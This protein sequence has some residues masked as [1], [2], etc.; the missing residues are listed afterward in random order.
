MENEKII[1]PQALIQKFQYALNNHWGYIWGTAG[2]LWTQARQT[3]IEQTTDSDRENARKYG[4]KWIG[5]YVADCSG[6]FTW[7]FKQLGGTMYHGSNTM[8]DKW[9]TAKGKLKN[10]RRN[11]GKTL[12]PGT[13]VFTYN[14]TKHNRGHVGLYIGDGWVIEA[15]GTKAGVVKSKVTLDKWVEWGELKGVDYETSYEGN[16]V[17]V[18]PSGTASTGSSA[19]S[20]KKDDKTSIGGR[21]T[22]RKGDKG[23]YV[24]LL[25]TKLQQKGYDLGSYGIDGD[26]GSATEKAVKQFQEDHDI[27]VDGI[28]GTGTWNKLDEQGTNL[29][30]VTIQHLTKYQAEALRKQY[31]GCSYMK[32][33]GR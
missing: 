8:W 17:V 16:G 20:N 27:K 2:V 12:L 33:E 3:Q 22:L 14:E 28:V 9:C 6:L 7:A 10:G 15:Q 1:S 31:D 32:E 4:S 30:T 18:I 23:E 24:T 19:V 11:D 21:P 26:F 29:Y 13:A 25:Q 5:H